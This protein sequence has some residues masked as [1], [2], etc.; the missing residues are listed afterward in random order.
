MSC[1]RTNVLKI[2]QIEQFLFQQGTFVK[3]IDCLSYL[4]N[5]ILRQ[6]FGTFCDY[7]LSELRTGN[8]IL[9]LLLL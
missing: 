4:L 9:F 3:A 1:F 5:G 7:F 8:L 6:T 2:F